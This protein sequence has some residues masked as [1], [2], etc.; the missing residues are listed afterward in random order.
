MIRAAGPFTGHERDTRRQIHATSTYKSYGYRR[1]RSRL[2]SRGTMVDERQSVK[3]ARA[4]SKFVRAGRAT[5]GGDRREWGLKPCSCSRVLFDSQSEH[6]ISTMSRK[7]EIAIPFTSILAVPLI[8]RVRQQKI[9]FFV[10]CR[11]V[12]FCSQWLICATFAVKPLSRV[13][14]CR[15]NFPL[16]SITVD[17]WAGYVSDAIN[18]NSVAARGKGSP[19]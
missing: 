11:S 8:L 1:Y 6:L 9:F 14:K 10:Q 3:C 19:K 13:Q 2:L 15:L 18:R 5:N 4:N 7:K 12:D 16:I 17:R